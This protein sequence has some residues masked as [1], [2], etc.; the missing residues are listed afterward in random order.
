MEEP[1]LS[2]VNKICVMHKQRKNGRK[3][4]KSSET[5]MKVRCSHKSVGVLF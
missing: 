2:Q 5:W 3:K 1:E 4:V